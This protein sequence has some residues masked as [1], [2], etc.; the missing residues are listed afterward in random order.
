[1]VNITN[2]TITGNGGK[3]I[4]HHTANIVPMQICT[5]KPLSKILCGC[6]PFF[7]RNA[8]MRLKHAIATMLS[9]KAHAYSV[10]LKP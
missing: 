10:L 9:M 7:K 6:A 5:A 2:N 8:V 4:K 1:M 3:A